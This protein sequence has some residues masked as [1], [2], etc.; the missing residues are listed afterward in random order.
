MR[1]QRRKGFKKSFMVLLTKAAWVT[2]KQLLE[3]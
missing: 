1:E 3:A 2:H